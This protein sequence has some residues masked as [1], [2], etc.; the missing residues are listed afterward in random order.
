MRSHLAVLRR[1][2]CSVSRRPATLTSVVLLGFGVAAFLQAQAVVGTIAKPGFIPFQMC[3][4]ERGD[5]LFVSDWGSNRVLVYD[6]SSLQL[7]GEIDPKGTPG[8]MVVD[9]LTGR[10]FVDVGVPFGPGSTRSNLA[11]ID[12]ERNARIS[13][14]AGAGGMLRKDE[15][16]GRI[17]SLDMVYFSP[18]VYAIDAATLAVTPVQISRDTP[19]SGLDVNPVTHQVFVGYVG[20]PWGASSLDIIEGLSLTRTTVP[21]VRCRSPIVNWLENKVYAELFGF[22][23]FWVYDPETGVSKEIQTIDDRNPGGND[24]GPEMFNPV[25]NRVYT[26]SEVNQSCTIIDCASDSYF[27]LPLPTAENPRVRL[28]TNHVY[29]PAWGDNVAVLLDPTQLLEMIPLGSLPYPPKEVAIGQTSGRVFVS[30]WYNSPSAT[31]TITV[32]Q[33]YE[34]MT[35]APVYVG[36]PPNASIIV[37]DPVSKQI[38]GTWGPGMLFYDMAAAISARP[39]GGRVYVPKTGGGVAVC[40]GWDTG[41]APDVGVATLDSGGS[42]PL[43]PICVPDGGRLYITNSASP[44]SDS[45]GVVDLVTNKLM[46]TVPVGKTPWGGAATP[47]GAKVYVANRDGNSVSVI[48]T[49]SHAVITTIPVGN[50]PWGVAIN[51][52]GTRA[53]VANS[54]SGTVSVIN[55][56]SDAVVGT[57]TVGAGPHWV[58]CAP[59][60]RRAFVTNSAGSTVSVIDV[61]AGAVVRTVPV[62]GKPEGLAVLPDGSAVYVATGAAVTVLGTSDFSTVTIPLEARWATPQAS[63]VAVADS[64]SKFAGCVTAAGAPLAGAVVR[65]LRDG[66]ERGTATTD[67]NGDY[68]IFNLPSGTYDVVVFRPGYSS[69]VAVDQSVGIGRTSL[70][71]FSLATDACAL[72]CGARVPDTAWIG[73]AQAVTFEATASAAVCSMVYD[74]DFGDGS[75]HASQPTATH[76]YSAPGTYRWRLLVAAGESTCTTTGQITISRVRRTRWR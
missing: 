28:S 33:D 38:I 58:A 35:H 67:P 42:K 14:I 27:N 62:V 65:T 26:N 3:V 34:L 75:N 25:S 19:P 30:T 46:T 8:G 59:D 39:G 11:V 29:F 47:D 1:A 18:V 57:L 6:C 56:A 7:L 49:A 22:G 48:S 63:S 15:N 69:R 76:N 2:L 68:S 5:K 41:A 40:A 52:S 51:P 74:W 61:G 43:A 9:E 45:V 60:G 16:L 13:T 17:Y 73:R 31:N 70:L 37:I 20:Y 36:D 66:S 50:G 53:F 21:G 64:T 12:A 54:G 71:P 23:G 24:A 4:Y 55:T 32:L 10:L 44:A 72:A